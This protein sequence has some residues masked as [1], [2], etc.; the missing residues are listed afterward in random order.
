MAAFCSPQCLYAADFCFFP[1]AYLCLDTLHVGCEGEVLFLKPKNIG[2]FAL[3]LG[4]SLQHT[5]IFS[6]LLTKY[7][8]KMLSL[9]KYMG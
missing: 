5:Y 6:C 9:P 3:V 7:I 8:F 2:R 4:S 1:L